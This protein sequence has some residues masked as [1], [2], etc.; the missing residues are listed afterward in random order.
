METGLVIGALLKIV[1][2]EMNTTRAN[3]RSVPVVK[4]NS[5]LFSVSILA[6]IA[7]E[8]LSAILLK[9]HYASIT[10]HLWD[11]SKNTGS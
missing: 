2:K 8:V 6:I 4:L 1:K 7:F 10:Y 3:A 11:I 9:L 5:S